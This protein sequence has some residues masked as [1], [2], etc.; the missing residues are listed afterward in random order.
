MVQYVRAPKYPQ[1]R[2]VEPMECQRVT[3]L[4][5]GDD[6]WYEIKYD[7]YRIIAVVSGPAVVLYLISG[8]DYTER[9]PVH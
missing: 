1:P 5:E 3:K 7:G 6:W 9:F 4:P 2:F 8:L